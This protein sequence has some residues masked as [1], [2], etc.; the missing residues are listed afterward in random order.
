MDIKDIQK[1]DT[2]LYGGSWAWVIAV[3]PETGEVLLSGW[4]GIKTTTA[5]AN[6]IQRRKDRE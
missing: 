4:R 2:V 5:Y 3:F 6:E 1:G